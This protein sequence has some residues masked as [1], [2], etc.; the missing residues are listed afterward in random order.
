MSREIALGWWPRPGDARRLLRPELGVDSARCRSGCAPVVYPRPEIAMVSH[1]DHFGI[2]M[3]SHC[4][5]FGQHVSHNP[6]P[7]SPRIEPA[8]VKASAFVCFSILQS[9]SSLLTCLSLSSSQLN[10]SLAD[11]SNLVT[12]FKNQQS[13]PLCLLADK[14]G[15]HDFTALKLSNTKAYQKE[16]GGVLLSSIARRGAAG[17]SVFHHEVLSST[18]SGTAETVI[19]SAN[20]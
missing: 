19:S 9:I 5:H 13:S 4:D 14:E 3:V 17:P 12:S 7:T 11:G 6:R 10:L 2:A 15:C 1:C 16:N 18:H 8:H 20:S